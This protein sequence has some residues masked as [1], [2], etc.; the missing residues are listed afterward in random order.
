M[1]R[2]YCISDLHGHF[3]IML[4]MLK[5]INFDDSDTLYVLGDCNDRGAFA[6]EIYEYIRAH[7][8][9][10]MIK[11]NHELMMRDLMKVKDWNKPDGRLWS[12]NGGKKTIEQFKKHFEDENGLNEDKFNKYCEDMINYIDSL[13]S[14]IELN[15]EGKDYVLV[16]SGINPEKTLYEQDEMECAWMREWFY[17]S[18]G[19][20]NKTIIFGHT[21]TILIDGRTKFGVWFDPVH[22]DKIGI[23]G[24]LANYKQGQLNCLC[25]NDLSITSIKL[26]EVL[27]G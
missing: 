25:L 22:K 12:Q 9:I 10:F 15:V 20:D 4:E 17:L 11:G 7:K 1:N 27:E 26:E 18:K 16:H 2:I 21:P 13:P 5:K 24:G 14:Y 23:D 19:L 8:N 3:Q 6:Y